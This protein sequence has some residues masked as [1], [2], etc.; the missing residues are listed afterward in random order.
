MGREPL[1]PDIDDLELD[2]A[3]PGSRLPPRRPPWLPVFAVVAM[4]LAAVAAWY[5][6]PRS[7][8]TPASV[9]RAES[10]AAVP[11]RARLPAVPGDDI[12]LPPLDE[13]DALVRELVS[14]L[15]SHPRTAAWLTSDHL[16]RD[17][18]A[19][20]VNIAEGNTPTPHLRQVP[21][22]GKF[23]IRQQGTLVYIDPSSYQRYDGHAGAVAAL[24]AR[25]AARLYATLKPRI[26]EAYLELG[27]PHGTF[28]RTLEKAIV[29]LLDTP[30]VE[31]EV[32]LQ[33]SSVAY[34]FANPALESLSHAQR[35]FLR[36]GPANMRLVQA[37]LRE[38]AGHLGI[39]AESLPRARV[40]RARS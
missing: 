13:M 17:F 33:S 5:Y 4:V 21:P 22:D 19:V 28:D 34:S 27:A 29:Q 25:G 8:A 40:V 37:K 9:P 24:D 36:M 1:V 15:S 12:I 23:R 32:P 16:I 2:R 39:P 26:E 3:A 7:G 6:W 14:K 30:I 18:V 11:P 10:D 38:I 35:Q 31:G 20:A